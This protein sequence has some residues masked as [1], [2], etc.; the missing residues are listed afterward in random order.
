M[1]Q[2]EVLFKAQAYMF[3]VEVLFEVQVYMPSP[4]A[5]PEGGSSGRRPSHNHNYRHSACHT[6]NEQDEFKS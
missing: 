4:L 1:F 6:Y 5:P 2:V 3:Q